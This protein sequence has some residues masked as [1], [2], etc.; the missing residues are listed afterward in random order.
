LDLEM[1]VMSST[2]TGMMTLRVCLRK[3]DR[4]V[5]L[6]LGETH[7]TEGV[8]KGL[9]PH[10]ASLL[11]SI[12]CLSEEEDITMVTKVLKAF[13]ELHV[14][15]FLQNTIEIGM[16]DVQGVDFH[17]FKSSKGKDGPDCRVAHRGQRSR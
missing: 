10:P 13:R 7:L 5:R 1:R 15:L 9:G 4:G 11:E 16:G 8:S 12:D 17:V 2:N 3:T 14:D 6:D